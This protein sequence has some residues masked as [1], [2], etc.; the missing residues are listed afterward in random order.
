MSSN[1][2]TVAMKFDTL[3]LVLAVAVIAAGISAFYYFG[4]HSLLLRVVGLL[5]CVGAAIVIA[6]QTDPGRIMWQ[7][8]AEAQIE[9]KKVVWPTRQETVQTTALVIVMVLAFAVVLWLLDLLLGG[10]IQWLIGH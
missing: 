10:I 4:D 3:K 7:F 5:A 9:V 6:L 1:A 2:E 8:L